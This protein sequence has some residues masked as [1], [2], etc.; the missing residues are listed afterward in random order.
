MNSKKT[1]YNL[2]YW[3][4]SW[5][6]AE[7]VFWLVAG[8]FYKYIEANEP[9]FRFE[10]PW[11]LKVGLVAVSIWL[12]LHFFIR[13]D[14]NRRTQKLAD[15][16][17]MNHLHAG[18]NSFK[19]GLKLILSRWA[20]GL[21]FI[22]AANPQYGE[23]EKEVVTEGI[24]IMIAL[25]VSNSMLAEDL[26]KDKS[27]L[28]VAK[29]GVSQL[30][31]RLAGDHIGIVIFAGN[32]YKQLPITTDYNIAK[33]FLSNISTNMVSSQG[34]NI[35][36]AI[37]ECMSSFDL[38][39]GTNK[40]ILVFSDGE[41]HE[42][43]AIASAKIAKENG[44]LVHTI[45]MGGTNGVPIPMSNG[46]FKTDRNGKKV[47]TKLNETMLKEVANA[48]GGI[49]TRANGYSIG[50]EGLINDL[51]KLE[52]TEFGK[53]K[54]LT[55]ADHFQVFLAIGLFLWLIQLTLGEVNGDSWFKRYVLK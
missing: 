22:A 18:Y 32:A 13:F 14:K 7:I 40:V 37:D 52:K 38:E 44:V 47:V 8:M 30:I 36:S 16:H 25:D 4:V 6:V 46:S 24:E 20:I 33:T 2:W 42:A 10:H 45:G 31:D 28:H 26:V 35:G 34:T 29:K 1:T 23:E 27:R 43:Q 50:I 53:G 21:F 15:A 11:I 17:L 54:F 51:K 12:L 55:Y 19:M 41:D 9:S 48:G 5:L 3:L 49:Y 39:N